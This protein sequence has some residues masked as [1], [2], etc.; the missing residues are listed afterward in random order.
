MGKKREKTK[1]ERIKA[2]IKNLRAQIAG[3]DPKRK[4]I[5]EGLIERAAFMRVS[6]DDMELDL[7]EKGFTEMFSQ[8]P[9]Q[10]EYERRRPT[11]DTYNS[12]NAS[13]Q[14]IIRQLTDLLPKENDGKPNNGDEDDGFEDFVN[15]R[16]DV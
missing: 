5:A 13:Y 15:G 8:S 9:T 6:L 16:G 11:A 4:A 7:V 3:L 12:M 2:E 1:E 14:K 10:K